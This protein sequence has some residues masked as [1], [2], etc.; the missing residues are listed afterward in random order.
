[1]RVSLGAC[2]SS[3][4][5]L[6]SAK[7]APHASPEHPWQSDENHKGGV[8]LGSAGAPPA[9]PRAPARHIG[10]PFVNASPW[11]PGCVPRGAEHRARGARAPRCTP[12]RI[13]ARHFPASSIFTP[14]TLDAID[15]RLVT[16][17]LALHC[18]VRFHLTSLARGRVQHREQDPIG[19]ALRRREAA[20]IQPQRLFADAGELRLEWEILQR[21]VSR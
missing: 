19:M 6:L 14:R 9:V 8:L 21:R 17:H 12:S 16:G 2:V 4:V 7:G 18:G 3:P 5:Q 20:G 13:S 10:R 1:M 11:V 15:R